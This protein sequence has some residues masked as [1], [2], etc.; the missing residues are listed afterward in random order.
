MTEK[1][2]ELLKKQVG[3]RIWTGADLFKA[4]IVGLFVGLLVMSPIAM[5]QP[6]ITATGT[7]RTPQIATENSHISAHFT[8][9]RQGLWAN[10]DTIKTIKTDQ[11][12]YKISGGRKRIT[13]YHKTIKTSCIS[14]YQRYPSDLEPKD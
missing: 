13:Q 9:G 12:T 4:F 11:S 1:D 6:V 8:C 3:P 10:L 2:W 7:G 14:D 5:A